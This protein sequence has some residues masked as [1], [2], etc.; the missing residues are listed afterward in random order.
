MSAP[1]DRVALVLSGGGLMGGV[2]EMGALCALD[3][4][5]LNRS[6]TE[7]DVYVGTSAGSVVAA[8]LANGMTPKRMLRTLAGEVNRGEQPQRRHLFTPDYEEILRR[9][10]ALPRNF[11]W[12][13]RH[14]LRNARDM[15]LLDFLLLF[16]EALPAGVLDPG[17]LEEWFAGVLR[18]PGRTDS[19]DALRSE[20]L[21]VAT[22]LDS[23]ERA[24]FGHGFRTDVA[25]SKAVAASCAIPVVYTPVRIG[26][27]DY[28]DGGVRGN[29]SLDLAVERGAKLI[30]CINP[31]VPY[32][33]TDAM[34][35]FLGPEH[36]RRLR[37]KGAPYIVGQI[38]R[39]WTHA[40]LQYQVKNLKRR[41]PEVDVVMIQPRRDD[42]RMFFHNVMR[43]SSRL[44]I[45]R[46]GYESV[47]VELDENFRRHR[48][49]FARHGLHVTRYIVGQQLKR[50]RESGYDTR[51]IREVLEQRRRRPLEV[52]SGHA[53]SVLAGTLERLDRRL[54]YLLEVG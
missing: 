45:A 52:R 46:H 34:I 48:E 37:H 2:Y 17:P 22:E 3:D 27:S 54:E 9:I 42:P 15:D 20:L 30:I 38:F 10:T 33:P 7:L 36:H 47:S 31:L 43:Y 19:F 13:V 29:T 39:T 4:V 50:I 53:T 5:L 26:G 8:C 41:H 35:P 21:V 6:L 14:Y 18:V 28:I 1:R 44:L 24:V 32:T 51:V 12:A 40:S 49:V 11:A 23:G 16:T 25:I